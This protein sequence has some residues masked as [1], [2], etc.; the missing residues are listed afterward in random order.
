MYSEAEI[1]L[2]FRW[3]SNPS[4]HFRRLYKTYCYYGRFQ[5]RQHSYLKQ[6]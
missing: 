6:H 2:S 1:F 4:L 5:K 3:K